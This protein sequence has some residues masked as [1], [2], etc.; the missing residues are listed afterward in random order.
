MLL[1]RG[2]VVGSS[3]LYTALREKKKEAARDIFKDTKRRYEELYSKEDREWFDKKSQEGWPMDLMRKK[4]EEDE[5]AIIDLLA[6]FLK[7]KKKG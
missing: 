5:D 1:Y 6:R 7:M 2:V 4:K 3:D